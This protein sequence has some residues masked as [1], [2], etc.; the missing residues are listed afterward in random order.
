MICFIRLNYQHINGCHQLTENI[1]PPIIVASSFP[2]MSIRNSISSLT[3]W[4]RKTSVFSIDMHK[5]CQQNIYK[6]TLQLWKPLLKGLA[7]LQGIPVLE[8]IYSVNV[9]PSLCSYGI[10]G[11]LPQWAYCRM[12]DVARDSMKYVILILMRISFF[13]P[14]SV[15]CFCVRMQQ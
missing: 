14:V 1:E 13:V 6:I 7:A 2:V 15:L 9:K 4:K 3:G 8:Y 5:K 12:H 10:T 11:I